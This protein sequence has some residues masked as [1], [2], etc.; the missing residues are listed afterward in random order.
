M[1]KSSLES[2]LKKYG[3][4]LNT[5]TGLI[6]EVI[7]YIS[8]SPCIDL[9]TGGGIPEGS[10]VSICGPPGCGK[11]TTAL[12]IMRNALLPGLEVNGQERKLFYLDV[13]HRIKK[14]NLSGITGLSPD[15]I[16][17]IRSTKEKI[18]SAQDY[19]DIAEN[20]I[21]DPANVGSVIVIDSASALCP[22]DELVA[23]TS[24]SI[25][26][27]QPKLMSHFCKKIAAPMKVMNVTVIIIQH[28]ITNTSGYGAKWLTDGGE[29]IKY[30]LDIKL[31]TKGAPTKWEEKDLTVGQIIEWDVVKSANCES[32][33]TAT[34]YLRF[35][36][37]LDDVKENISIAIDSGLI[38]KSG[39][40]Y[41]YTNE[42]TGETV[43]CQG[44]DNLYTSLKNDSVTYN[45]IDS[46]IRGM[47]L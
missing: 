39:A 6:D 8:I 15:K 18:L 26:T 45:K 44:E 32:G 27:T 40:W 16:Q 37:G 38:N 24:G 35:G 34:S 4:I 43:K 20:L 25:R 31:M 33:K 12:Q 19:L 28:L 1:S 46:V 2:I 3:K 14:M 10:F 21:K 17:L 41:S 42:S 9:A 11:S 29:K 47:L 30:Q 7:K 22:A 13:E 36:K 23:D 5:G